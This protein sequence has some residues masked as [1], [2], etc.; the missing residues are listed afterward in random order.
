MG[1]IEVYTRVLREDEDGTTTE[2]WLCDACYSELC[3]ADKDEIPGSFTYL[4]QEKDTHG[5]KEC[6][7]CGHY[8]KS[9]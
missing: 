9:F 2:L 8:S 7:I 3:S 5:D 6:D 4:T 1:D